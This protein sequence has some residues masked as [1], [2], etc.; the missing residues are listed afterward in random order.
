MSEEEA[1]PLQ[2]T[3]R[4]ELPGEANAA[5]DFLEEEL[6][7][8]GEETGAEPGLDETEEDIWA[9]PSETS[10]ADEVGGS[11]AEPVD[12][13]TGQGAE[14]GVEEFEGSPDASVPDDE[15]PAEKA[16]PTSAEEGAGAPGSGSVPGSIDGGDE[17]TAQAGGDSPPAGA[18][19]AGDGL[20]DKA[21][22]LFEYLKGLSAGL[23]AD[24]REEF[25]ASGVKEK[26][27]HLIDEL[28][29]PESLPGLEPQG[30]GLRELA[31]AAR[32]RP[33]VPPPPRP[34]DP[35]RNVSTRR[36]ADR[37]GNPDRRSGILER[38]LALE[39]RSQEDRRAS[40]DR[41]EPEP[42]IELPPE[43]PPEAVSLTLSAEGKPLEIAGLRV[44]P[45]LARLLDL[46]KAEKYRGTR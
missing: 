22:R 36:T 26:L 8:E 6:L 34:V 19:E 21:L 43:I 33:Y 38:R 9:E 1:V 23:P 3:D 20:G 37:R 2:E 16:E 27:E 32:A 31:E 29:H 40:V 24:K 7:P 14:D 17:S 41:R 42:R 11:E 10:V 45:K 15:A 12:T 13:P 30:H 4:E 39:R 44:S 25:E 35:R 46:L 5:E 18:F 28:S